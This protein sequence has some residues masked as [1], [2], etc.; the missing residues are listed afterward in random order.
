[1]YTLF[2]YFVIKKQNHTK[3]AKLLSKNNIFWFNKDYVLDPKKCKKKMQKSCIF[4]NNVKINSYL[5]FQGQNLFVKQN[6]KI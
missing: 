6:K 1:M 4:L 5:R 2:F 3:K